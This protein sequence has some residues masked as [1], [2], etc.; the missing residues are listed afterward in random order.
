MAE[1]SFCVRTLSRCSSG[2]PE[3]KVQIRA[4]RAARGLRRGSADGCLVEPVDDAA[5]AEEKDLGC[6]LLPCSK[7]NFSICLVPSNEG[8]LTCFCIEGT[9]GRV[10]GLSVPLIRLLSALFGLTGVGILLK[11]NSYP[12]QGVTTAT[13]D[14]GRPGK[15]EHGILSVKACHLSVSGGANRGRLPLERSLTLVSVPTA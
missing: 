9:E 5:K 8:R 10:G 14:W 4:R 11:S 6:F 15:S 2:Q 3:S 1:A 7:C 12:C 13:F